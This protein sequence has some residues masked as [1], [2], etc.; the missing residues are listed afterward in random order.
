MSGIVGMFRQDGAPVDRQLL[1]ALTDYI[2]YRGPDAS[3]IWHKGELG[4]GH[5]LLKTTRESCGER[6]PLSLNDRIWMTADARLD[7]RAALILQ[8]RDSSCDIG[9]SAPDSELILRSY[10]LW[11]ANCVD[12][13][14]G[15][16]AFAIWDARDMV[17]FCARDHFGIKPFYYAQLKNLFL[18]SNTLNCVR[19]HPDVSGEL[20]DSAIA[21]FLLFGLNL[22]ETTTTFRDVQRL[23]PA[24]CMTVS[25]S[26]LEL[27][28]Y[29]TPPTSARIRYRRE[30]EYVEHFQALLRAAVN[31]RLRTDRLG[32]PLSGG[33]DST[34][35]AATAKELSA[36]NGGVP[37]IHT[38]T[39]LYE[40]LVPDREIDY[41]SD[42]AKYLGLPNRRFAMDHLRPFVWPEDPDCRL[43]EPADNPFFA[44]PFQHFHAVAQDCRVVLSGEG[45][46]NLMYFQM[47]PYVQELWRNRQWSRL[48]GEGLRFLW[49]RPFPWRGIRARL[50]GLLG[51]VSGS[52]PFPPWIA[53]D[54]ARRLYLND[55]WRESGELRMPAAPHAV[56]PKA[57]A[58]LAL[59]HWTSMFENENAGVTRYPVDVRYPFLDLRLVE[60]LLALPPFPWFFHKRLLREA[61][62]GKLPESILTRPKTPFRADPLLAHFQRYDV[63]W[64]NQ[65]PISGELERYINRSALLTLH[66]N[67]D[68]EQVILGT[69][70]HCLN[71]WLQS[72]RSPRSM[73][74]VEIS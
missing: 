65:T 10:A 29:W 12:H 3:E 60:Y 53:P 8:L 14:R 25:R 67:M 74:R 71:F 17:L 4:L 26:G 9:E 57:H 16:F 2:S 24:H 46:D 47:W 23:P 66:G 1:Q 39:A 22:D 13:L 73:S 61:M 43:P 40:S 27:R 28:Q 51:K 68:P 45:N 31:D 69:R 21:D 18:F 64:V 6:Q 32:I 70:P 11:G 37:C 58:S 52:D 55:R 49:I 63:N 30:Q 33:L 5:T 56:R 15:D 19:A 36:S 50:A 59:P 20:N 42:A 34:S 72:V 54:F 41:A 48:S 44:A 7:E 35:L 38:Y 62:A